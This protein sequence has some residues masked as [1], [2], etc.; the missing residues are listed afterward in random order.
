MADATGPFPNSSTFPDGTAIPRDSASKRERK[1][2]RKAREALTP[3]AVRAVTEGMEWKGIEDDRQFLFL[4]A[5]SICGV[6]AQSAR[7]AG[8]NR[9][10][11]YNRWQHNEVFAKHME[12]AKTKIACDLL[13]EEAWRRALDGTE[14]PVYHQGMQVGS[15]TRYSDT[16]LVQLLRGYMPEKYGTKIGVKHSADESLS[17]QLDAMNRRLDVSREEDVEAPEKTTETLQ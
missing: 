12:L 6:V 1:M 14:E 17:S 15:V 7:I 8:V 16:L 3:E 5:L 9:N 10:A 2:R 13:E 4:S 11:I